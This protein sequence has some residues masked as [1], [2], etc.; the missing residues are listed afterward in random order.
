VAYGRDE[1]WTQNRIQTELDNLHYSRQQRDR[2]EQSQPAPSHTHQHQQQLTRPPHAGPSHTH[3]HPQ[4]G[5]SHTRQ[6]RELTESE[7]D[8]NKTNKDNED[9]EPDKNEKKRRKNRDREKER[10]AKLYA[11]AES[12]DPETQKK[13]KQ[14]L[15]ELKAQMVER[16]ARLRQ[17]R[18]P[19]PGLQ[20]APSQIPAVLLL[21]PPPGY[22]PPLAYG[23]QP[24]EQPH[25]NVAGPSWTNPYSQAGHQRPPQPRPTYHHPAARARVV[26]RT[27][28]GGQPA[29]IGAVHQPGGQAAMAGSGAARSAH[30]RRG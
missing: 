30:H 15:E 6:Q 3:H 17:K 7:S 1:G 21:Q 13:V 25:S 2:P 20:E 18:L 16:N 8:H 26:H 28:P 24:P 29:A 27:Q 5:P 12:S 9:Q 19:P 10:R 22:A 11:D 4:A 14:K 23:A